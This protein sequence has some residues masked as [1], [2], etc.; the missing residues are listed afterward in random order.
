MKKIILSLFCILLLQ[1]CKEK[2]KKE[3]PLVSYLETASVEVLDEELKLILNPEDKLEI[4]AEGHDWT[5]GP[6]WIDTHKM[7]LFSDIPRNSV[8]SWNEKT[9][10]QL[11]LSPS[12]F[13]GENFEGSEPGA[14]GLLL[15]PDG[16]L[17]LCQHGNR[18]VVKMDSP[19]K[20]PQ[21]NFIPLVD[22][23]QGKKLNSPNDAV[24]DS[25]GNLFFTDPPYGLPQQ[26]DDKSKELNFQGVFKSDLKGN[27]TLIDS[28]LSRPNGIAFSPDE[29]R[30]FVANSDPNNAIWVVYELDKEGTVLVKKTFFDTTHLT[31]KEKGLPDGLKINKKGYLF[32]TG[33]GG[34]FIF[35]PN[36]K[37]L[38]TIKTGQATSNVALNNN[39]NELFITADSYVLK[40]NLY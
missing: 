23:Y 37:H 8:Y 3:Q 31:S 24:F 17:V 27:I 10:T 13:T 12:G 5:E 6:L 30:L 29:K 4:L 26:M 7:L 2:I 11:Y 9:G 21:A 18:Q 40:L 15:D 38:G 16:H 20:N 28:T 39:E 34:V 19:L 14:N 25:K 35:N 33:P 32:A 36:G 1:G 22:L